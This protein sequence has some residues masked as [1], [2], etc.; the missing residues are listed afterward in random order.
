[1]LHPQ[2]FEFLAEKENFR[3]VVSTNGHF[4]S[5]ETSEK[6]VNSNL[7]RLIVSLDG[8]TPETYSVYRRKGNFN[9]VLEGIGNVAEAIKRRNSSL[10]LVI[11][12][13][14]NRSNEAQIPEAKSYANEVKAVLK[15]KSMQIYNQEEIDYWQP[16]GNKFRRYEKADGSYLIRN[17]LRN[18]CR[19]LWFNPVITWDGKVVPCCF[20][21]DAEHIMGDLKKKSFREIW[22][23]SQYR[24]FRKRVLAGRNSIE[25]CS[26]CTSGLKRG[27]IQ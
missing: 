27:I 18:N 6:L 17:S 24:L 14:V 4:L 2:F 7:Y 16:S 23:D 13:L 8:M 12:F 19:R 20:D 5:A 15:L 21:K 11:Q 3:T 25:I 22:N 10:Q 26:N 1:M 9:T